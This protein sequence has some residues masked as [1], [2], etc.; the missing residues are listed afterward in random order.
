MVFLGFL[1]WDRP[2]IT[3]SRISSHTLGIILVCCMGS[4]M[5]YTSMCL[6][7][8]QNDGKWDRKPRWKGWAAKPC[9]ALQLLPQHSADGIMKQSS[10]LHLILY[11][12]IA[13]AIGHLISWKAITGPCFIVLHSPVRAAY[14]DLADTGLWAVGDAVSSKGTVEAVLRSGI[15][16]W[17]AA[18]P[19][20]TGEHCGEFILQTSLAE[21]V[22]AGS[23]WELR[24]YRKIRGKVLN[25]T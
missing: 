11:Q 23:C 2:R 10:H 5:T 15:C 8:G 16:C 19:G 22:G 17:G 24:L 18:L 6:L 7:G 1:L 14:P 13:P 21:M 3:S 9:C 12:C 25:S 4:E 20:L